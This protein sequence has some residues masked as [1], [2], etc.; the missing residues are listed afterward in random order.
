MTEHALTGMYNGFSV[1]LCVLSFMPTFSFAAVAFACLM[2]GLVR[3]QPNFH[4]F[5]QRGA[6]RNGDHQPPTCVYCLYV[7]AAAGCSCPT[8]V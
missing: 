4:A 6:N 5:T 7:S 3:P 2:R 1:L 8:D